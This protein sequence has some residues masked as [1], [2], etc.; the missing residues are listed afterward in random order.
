MRSLFIFCLA[1]CVMGMNPGSEL[2]S[3]ENKYS[4]PSR[5][6]SS[7]DFLNQF[8]S[9]T[10]LPRRN[11]G[12][13]E[14]SYKLVTKSSF[15]LNG[16]FFFLPRGNNQ[17][18]FHR[19]QIAH[20][21]ETNVLNVNNAFLTKGRRCF[22][23]L[24]LLLP[25]DRK[26]SILPIT[27]AWP[28]HSTFFV[29]PGE[30]KGYCKFYNQESDSFLGIGED[31]IDPVLQAMSPP[32]SLYGGSSIDENTLF[33]LVSADQDPRSL[34]RLNTSSVPQSGRDTRV[35]ATHGRIA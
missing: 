32:H 34:D 7:H 23:L 22:P 6:A 27:E 31:S 26:V 14:N 18:V 19:Y 5:H 28:N 33:R 13:A 17:E 8:S 3:E 20:T 1:I 16:T 25:E 24:S 2:D 29:I 9:D 21:I 30:H 15:V 4:S 11:T 12:S 35:R 10:S